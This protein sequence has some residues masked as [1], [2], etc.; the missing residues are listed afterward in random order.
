[1]ITIV[2]A[3]NHEP[4]RRLV[5]GT[6]TAEPD[7]QVV[8]QASGG[9][10]AIKLAQRLKPDILIMDLPMSGLSGIEVIRQVRERSPQT[11]VIVWSLH[12]AEGYVMEAFKAGAKGYLPKDSGL[13][14]L[15]TAIR[16]V[17]GGHRYLS[18]S[19]RESFKLYRQK[20]RGIRR[21]RKP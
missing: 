19:L 11:K 4:I 6:L 13:D 14:E 3:E 12:T 8:G 15:A 7:F 1:M 16:E 18:P 21:R 5:R 20:V 9:E 2:L 10:R 17:M